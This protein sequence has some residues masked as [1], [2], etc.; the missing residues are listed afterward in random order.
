[1][2]LDLCGV[3]LIKNRYGTDERLT[4]GYIKDI[5]EDGGY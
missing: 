2:Q 3:E 5:W 1:V 4:E